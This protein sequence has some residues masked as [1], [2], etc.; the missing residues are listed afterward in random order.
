[1]FV[2]SRVAK[3]QKKLRQRFEEQFHFSITVIDNL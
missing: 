3:L 1:M 2:Q